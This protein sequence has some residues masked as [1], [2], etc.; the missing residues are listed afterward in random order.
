[1]ART[2]RKWIVGLAALGT[3]MA[4]ASPPLTATALADERG[5]DRGPWHG[6]DIRHFR[7]NDFH[8]WRGG[9]WVHGRHG[10]RFGWWWVVG[11]VWYNYPAPVYPYPNPYVPPAVVTQVPPPGAVPQVWYYCPSVGGYYPYVTACPEG[12]QQVVPQP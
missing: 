10:G 8:S 12:W 4:L 2:R 11:G 3:V 1:M 6:R 9:H 5:H 7:D